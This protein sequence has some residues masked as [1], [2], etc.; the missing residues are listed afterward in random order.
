M[1]SPPPEIVAVDHFGT[2]PFD[3]RGPILRRW[4]WS[5]DLLLPDSSEGFQTLPKRCV[6]AQSEYGWVVFHGVQVL[7]SVPEEVHSYWHRALTEE[8][9]AAWRVESSTWLASFDQRHLAKCGHYI[10]EFYDHIVEVICEELI[11]GKGEFQLT[12]V[13][14]HEGRLR[15]AYM[16]RALSLSKL[17]RVEEA[18]AD[19]DR[20]IAT[21]PDPTSLRR[22][23]R[24]RDSH[25]ALLALTRILAES[26]PDAAA[27][28]IADLVGTLGW[29]ALRSGLLQILYDNSKPSS[30]PPCFEA[31]LRLINDER[32]TVSDSNLVALALHRL[33]QTD[34]LVARLTAALDVDAAD[35]GVLRELARLRKRAH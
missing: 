17:K 33:G 35:P 21:S 20:Y 34:E 14:P 11:I 1:S 12:E 27:E 28:K 25:C 10:L 15:Y 26:A 24:Y 7:Q 2:F 6:G 4:L 9:G 29:K 30:W 5:E 32:Q 16:R 23:Q 3:G 19:F 22:A 31:H 8:G 13:L 18:L